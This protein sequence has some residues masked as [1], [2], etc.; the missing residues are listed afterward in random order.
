LAHTY[1]PGALILESTFTSIP[2]IASERFPILPVRPLARIN[3]ATI[4]RLPQ[5]K[6]PIFLAHSPDDEVIPYH[7]GQ[8]LFAIAPEP[9]IFFQM[10]GGH[11][12]GFLISPNYKATLSAFIAEHISG[13]K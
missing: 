3:Y 5:V 11:N 1:T 6:A 13:D 10:Q 2:N 12:D 7:H 8:Q 9:K 4:D